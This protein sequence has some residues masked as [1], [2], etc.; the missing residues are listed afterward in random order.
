MSAGLKGIRCAVIG[1]DDRELYLISELQQQGAYIVGV[2]FEKASPIS[3][4]TLAPSLEEAVGQVDVLLFPLF[5]T[6]ECG[7]VKAKYSDSPIVLNK[8]VLEAIPAQVPLVIGFAR[9]DLK[10]EANN[11]GIK[12]VETSRLDELVILNSIPSAE[13]AIQMAMEATTITI[14]GSNSFVLGLGRCGWTL[15]HMLKGIGARVTGVARKPSDLARAVE[16]GLHAVD[17][18]NLKDEIGHAEIIFNTVPHQVLDRLMLEKVTPDAV[19]VDLAS[20]PGGTDFEY[21]QNLGIKALLA[22]GLPG[23]VAPKTAGRI[24]AHIYPQLILRHLT[25]VNT[26]CKVEV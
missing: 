7:V 24:L 5:G 14:H 4:M 9:P 25:T 3:G 16:M 18:A 6:D 21:A 20:R 19:I 26:T 13:G 10:S 15:A 23:T 11:L 17:F 12:L 1:G 22:P 8:K 2:G